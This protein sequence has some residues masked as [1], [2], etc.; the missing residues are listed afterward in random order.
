[1]AWRLGIVYGLSGRNVFE[2]FGRARDYFFVAY[3]SCRGDHRAPGMIM[4]RAIGQEIIA[5]HTL[6]GIR[7]AREW[8]AQRM[9]GPKM[10]IE[11]LLHVR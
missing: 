3:F 9:I 5:L 2:K 11:Y 6:N 4:G 10:P 7:S 8:T 1:M